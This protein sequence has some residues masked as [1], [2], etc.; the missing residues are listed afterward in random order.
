MNGTAGSTGLF[1]PMADRLDIVAVRIEHEGAIIARVVRNAQAG[2]AVVGAARRQGC[3]IERVNRRSVLRDEGD[4][5]ARRGF[6]PAREPEGMVDDV[7]RL[8]L[9]RI[10]PTYP[11]TSGAELER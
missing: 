1:G 10:R 7:H 6:G 4:V 3:F 2:P 11:M 5:Q 9:L 8:A